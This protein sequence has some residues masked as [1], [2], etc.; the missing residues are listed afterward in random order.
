M[1]FAHQTPT[2]GDYGPTDLSSSNVE[3]VG[4][5]ELNFFCFFVQI[6]RDRPTARAWGVVREDPRFSTDGFRLGFILKTLVFMCFIR[7]LVDTFPT[8]RGLIW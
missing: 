3:R 4:R 8:L 1:R 2:A 5:K 7:I 6:F